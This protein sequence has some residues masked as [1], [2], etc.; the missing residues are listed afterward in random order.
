MISA[1]DAALV[2][3]DGLPGI[4]QE[5]VPPDEIRR[6]LRQLIDL[7]TRGLRDASPRDAGPGDPSPA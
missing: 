1:R 6:R 2:L 7:V 5:P 3:V 4:G